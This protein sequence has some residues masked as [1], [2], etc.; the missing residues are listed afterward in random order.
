MRIQRVF[1]VHFRWPIPEQSEGTQIGEHSLMSLHNGV[2]DES[3]SDLSTA[4]PAT[5]QT[6]NGVLRSFDGLELDVDLTLESISL[7]YSERKCS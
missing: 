7:A 3:S 6:F 5:V 2:G 4:E 1:S